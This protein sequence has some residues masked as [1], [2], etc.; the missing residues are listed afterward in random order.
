MKPAV[1]LLAVLA[2]GARR[3]PAA[4]RSRRTLGAA[5]STQ[6]LTVMLDY[7]P[8]ADHVG[9]YQAPAERRL[10]QGRARRRTSRCHPDPSAPLKL[11]AAGKADVAISYEP[12]VLLARDQGLR[13][14]LGGGDRPAARSPRSWLWAPSTS[15]SPPA[16]AARR[17]ATAGIP[18]QPAYLT[19][20]PAAGRRAPRARSRRSTSASTSSRRCCRARSTRP[21]AR[22]W[23]YEAIQLAQQ[24]QA[25]ER[26]PH[27]PGRR[28]HLRRARPRRAQVNTIVNPN[29]P[30]PPLRAGARA[31]LSSR[32]G[33]TRSVRSR[34]WSTP[35]RALTASS[36][37]RASTPRC[38]PSS[39]ATPATRGAGSRRRNGTPTASGCWAT[40]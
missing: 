2:A 14:G 11:L 24:Q 18:Y 28:A 22:F 37:W 30:D 15:R 3:W 32:P 33:A 36:S 5:G 39:R 4:A 20:D 19:D 26:D 38:R 35:T 13:A 9:I 29:D 17:S 8:N 34:T 27:G 25:P 7:L 1:V 40:T 12:E 16:C 31:R 10:H 6:Q 23:N 21:W